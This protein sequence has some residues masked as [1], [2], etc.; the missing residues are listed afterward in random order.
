M[1]NKRLDDELFNIYIQDGKTILASLREIYDKGKADG[2][3]KGFMDGVNDTSE[4]FKSS[5]YRQEYD[6]ELLDKVAE[7]FKENI[8][9]ILDEP[10][11]QHEGET[12]QNGLIIASDSLD[13][14]IDKMKAEVRENAN[15]S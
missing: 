12:W 13:E 8:N 9:T 7:K 3:N 4:R 5:A 1:S 15:E 2:Y 6:S 11:Y 14:V 10:N